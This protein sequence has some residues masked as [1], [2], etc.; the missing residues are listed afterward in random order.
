MRKWTVFLLI[1]AMTVSVLAVPASARAVR[2]KEEAV[3]VFTEADNA[4]IEQDVFASIE[5]LKT[6]AAKTC[7]GIG[8]MR[9]QD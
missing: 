1:L 7:G 6:N 9:A 2:Q 5:T 4:L 8:R 3:Y